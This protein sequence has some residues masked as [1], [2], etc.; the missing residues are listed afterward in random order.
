MIK[1]G[2]GIPAFNSTVDAGHIGM[3]LSFGSALA[4]NET[5]FE[6][7]YF[8]A[9]SVSNVDIVR[10]KL[11]HAALEAGCDWF[12]MV[13]ADNYIED[14]S[15]LLR[16]IRV[17]DDRNNESHDIAM[18]GMPVVCRSEGH[19]V[20]VHG[21]HNRVGNVSEATRIGSAIIAI[22]LNW[23]REHWPT[24][25]WFVTIPEEGS[26]KAKVGEDFYFCD[27]VLSRGAKILVYH[28][29]VSHHVA[30]RSLLTCPADY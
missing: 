20:N 1:V 18:I 28:G 13:D 27:S 6:L 7:V 14:G 10:N 17:A 15:A 26:H 21:S 29:E 3:W 11:T 30:S 9:I 24:P 22:N 25:P 23:L 12:I 16:M 19:P 2:V 4:Y 5:R 8:S